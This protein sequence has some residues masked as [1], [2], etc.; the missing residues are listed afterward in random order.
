MSQQQIIVYIEEA[1]LIAQ[2]TNNYSLYLAKMVNN[3]FTAI[4]FSKAAK[5]TVTQPSYQY[6]NIFDISSNSFMINFT[7]T[8]FQEGDITFT[9]GGKNLP[10]NMGQKTTLNEYGVFSPATNGGV[11][12][13]VLINNQLPGNPREILLDSKG[14]NI[15]VNC[16]GG[17]SIGA[18]T[19]TPKNQF[20]LW[21][22]TAQAVGSLIAGN[23]S[24]S[25]VVTVND[26]ET[27]TI[28][29]ND[30]GV[31]VPGEP[32][33]HLTDDQVTALHARVNKAVAMAA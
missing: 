24:N 19:M 32:A 27:K 33:T 4:W 16:S 1:Q 13:D 10:I 26:G 25:Y 28:T 3:S 9:S 7:N 8:P 31:W 18:T 17:M 20:Q 30:S 6:K 11:S 14:N 2:K 22:G 15:W 12:G 5:A 23:V 29:Y 21:F